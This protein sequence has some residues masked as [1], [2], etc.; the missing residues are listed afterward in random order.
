MFLKPIGEFYLTSAIG[1]H[2]QAL[3]HYTTSERKDGIRL[4]LCLLVIIILCLNKVVQSLAPNLPRSE[5][6]FLDQVPRVKR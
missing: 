2:V 5:G 6:I 4:S 3:G 1:I